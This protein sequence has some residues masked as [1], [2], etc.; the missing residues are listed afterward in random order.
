MLFRSL[1]A[2]GCIAAG[3]G[4]PRTGGV[5][6]VMTPD[7]PSHLQV[8]ALDLEGVMVSGG[9]ACASGK[10]KPMEA[11]AAMGFPDRLSGCAVRASGGWA[12]VEADWIRFADVMSALV[13][14]RAARAAQAA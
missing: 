12:T 6:A 8:M 10:V 11:L 5:L 7:Y 13:E 1:E 3:A 9:P 4:A 2:L 14:R